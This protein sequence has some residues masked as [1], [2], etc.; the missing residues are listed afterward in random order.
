MNRKRYTITVLHDHK[1]YRFTIEHIP[2]DKRIEQFKLIAR[3]KTFMIESN[4]LSP[5]I[6]A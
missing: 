5:A 1:R 6:R 2:V 3:N 4:S